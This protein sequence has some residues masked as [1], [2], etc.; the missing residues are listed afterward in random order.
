MP[1][2]IIREMLKRHTDELMAVPGVVGVGEGKSRGRPCITV[3]VVARTPDLLR[4]IPDTI[5]GYPVQIEESGELH[6]L[7]T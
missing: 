2:N 6:K 4:Q 1:G 3:F 5:E 7:N